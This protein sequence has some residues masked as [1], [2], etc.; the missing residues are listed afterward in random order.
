MSDDKTKKMNSSQSTMKMPS[1][2]E[3]NKSSIFEYEKIEIGSS[4]Q[5]YEILQSL[6]KNTGEAEVFLLKKNDLKY[7]LKLYYPNFS[8]KIEIL[9]KITG[10]N[11]PDIINIY[12]YGIHENRFYEILDFAEGGTLADKTPEGKF[13][14]I[15]MKEEDVLQVVR[16]TVNALEFCHTHG[17]IHRDIK[18]GN[19]FFKNTNG[20]DVLVGD[21][22]ISSELD[23]EG[24]M[25]KRITTPSRT[26]GYAAPEIYSGVIGKEIDYYA[27]G[28]TIFE[29]LIGE[30]AFAGRN[31]GHIMRDTMQGRVIEDFLS[32]KESINLS[33]RIKQLLRGLLTVK[34]EKRWGYQE[35]SRFL[36]GETISVFQEK[37]KEIP[38]LKINDI[39]CNDFTEIAKAL[40]NFPETSKKMLYRGMISRWAETFDS[41]LALKIGDI[42]EDNKSAELQEYGL[43]Q[44]IYLLDPSTPYRLNDGNE[45]NSFED[46]KDLIFK[47]N[48]YLY[49]DLI[50]SE[51]PLFA[52]LESRNLKDF[53]KNIEKVNKLNYKPKK[54]NSVL[55]VS[56]MSEGF[57]T[58]LDK[59]ILLKNLQLFKNLNDSQKE[60]LVELAKDKESPFSLWLEFNCDKQIYEIWFS[61]KIHQDLKHWNALIQNELVYHETMYL[62]QDEKTKTMDR[63][64]QIQR[65]EESSKKN[66]LFPIAIDKII[67][68]ILFH[69]FLIAEVYLF[70][71]NQFHIGFAL[72]VIYLIGNAFY[73]NTSRDNFIGRLGTAN[74]SFNEK[75]YIEALEYSKNNSQEIV[76]IFYLKLL[77]ESKEKILES[78]NK[79]L[80]KLFSEGGVFWS[81]T[82]CGNGLYYGFNFSTAKTLHLHESRKAKVFLSNS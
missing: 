64:L 80:V 32:R 74:I 72:I 42:E 17:I 76:S 18:P 65:L 13:K 44:L 48:Q 15:P 49:N 35:V 62:T 36:N 67:L 79:N 60:I 10:I 20:S 82:P 75:N 57:I 52:W 6:S 37:F 24:G 70:Y 7:V 41:T 9:D 68:A 4:F 5:E 11:H 71:I 33:N 3:K 63:E 59:N 8:A 46:L 1:K 43:F 45:I 81:S 22:G 34:H 28:I 19:L 47:N 16:E 73:L 54:Y 53:I 66:H 25:S 30:N 2:E 55:Q 40:S 77:Y 29:L 58:H 56:L 23:I 38:P 27:L 61:G 51:S 12:E 50:S 21:F 14:Y 78:K 26:E 69:L 39:E 31:Q